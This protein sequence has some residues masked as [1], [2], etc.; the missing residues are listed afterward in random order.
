M[1]KKY[2]ILSILPL[3]VIA[4]NKPFEV[5]SG[6]IEYSIQGGGYLSTET[7]L[8]IKGKATVYFDDWGT[9]HSEQEEGV[10]QMTGAIQHKETV[11]KLIYRNK[12]N[13]TKVDYKKEQLIKSILTTKTKANKPKIFLEEGEAIILGYPCKIWKS[14]DIEKCIY[15]GIVLKQEARIFGIIY[16][17]V[18]E[19]IIFDINITKEVYSLPNYPQKEIGLIEGK[20]KEKKSKNICTQLKELEKKEVFPLDKRDIFINELTKDIFEKQKILLPQFLTVLKESRF[21]LETAE[22]IVQANTCLEDFLSMT[23]EFGTHQDDY[24]IVWNAEKKEKLLSKIEKK[25]R[26]LE[27]RISCI[28]PAK[29]FHDLSKCMK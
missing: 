28:S 13:V 25:L 1:L 20:Q 2:F 11:K 22:N 19:E 23:E 21:C 16:T 4:N 6:L 10:L 29:H 5:K 15:K 26:F 27:A 9:I 3:L 17:K 18:A 14:L 8:T 12:N 7:N 24:I